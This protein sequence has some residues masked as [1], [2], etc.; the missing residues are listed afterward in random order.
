M[1]YGKLIT[2]EGIDGAGKTTL[3]KSLAE[4]LKIKY[5]VA[6][7]S[8]PTHGFYGMKFREA[9]SNE[10]SEPVADL[11]LMVLDKLDHQVIIRDYLKKG[12]WV[13]C[14]RYVMSTQVYQSLQDIDINVINYLCKGL[15]KPDLELLI[16]VEPEEAMKRIN[17]RSVKTEKYEKIEKLIRLRELYL[18]FA[19][20]TPNCISIPSTTME[21]TENRCFDA[22]MRQLQL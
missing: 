17:A 7:E 22:I 4:I 20:T 10:Q 2:I 9:L 15:V 12:T 16:D 18:K 3:A 5:N 6:V 8:E 11:C 19:A 1:K 13:I 14:D 21:E